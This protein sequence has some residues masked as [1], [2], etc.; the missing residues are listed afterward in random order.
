MYH[1]LTKV[2]LVIET[3]KNAPTISE[4]YEQTCASK[5]LTIYSNIKSALKES[6]TSF[7]LD[8]K[9]I[10]IDTRNA[11]K[12]FDV[13]MESIKINSKHQ[14]NNNAYFTNLLQINLS[15]NMLYDELVISF[16]HNILVEC[17]GL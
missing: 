15:K 16:V 1:H 10:N 8:L 14:L 7:N 4:I 2:N 11:S 6:E 5:S 9:N 13:I 12:Q 3:F 17:L